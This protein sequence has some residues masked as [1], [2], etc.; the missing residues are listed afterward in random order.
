MGDELAEVEGHVD[1]GIGAAERLAVE[2]DAKRAMQLP[3]APALA[4]RFRG[5][6]NGR[7]RA[8]RLRLKK[9]ESLGQFAG[10]Q[11]SEERRVGKE[12]VRTCR[13]RWSPYQQKKRN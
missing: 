5:H 6:E 9:A 4:E 7:H 1:A 3:V 11:R 2:V 13:S 12:C 8:R 10:A